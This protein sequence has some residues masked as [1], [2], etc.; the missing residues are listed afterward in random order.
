MARPH[1][2][3]LAGFAATATAFGPGRIGFG[4]FLPR[5]REAFDLSEAQAGFMTSLGFAAFLA[6]LPLAALIVR[7]AGP[8]TP[9]LLGALSALTGFVLVA[10]ASSQVF[11]AA[12]V[13]FAG[14]SAG[15]CWTPF[16]TAA[17]HD[18]S[19]TKRAAA[20]S[21]VSTGATLGVALAAGSFLIAVLAGLSWRAPWAV[22]AVMALFALALSGQWAPT[23]PRRA[24]APGP[25]LSASAFLRPR[26]I[27]LYTAALGFGLA[28]GA[29]L[30][31][32][33]VQVVSAGGLAGL[34]DPAASAAIFLIYGVCGLIGLASGAIEARIGL[35]AF[36][37]IIFLAFAA[38]LALIALF[39]ASWIG[40]GASAGLQGAAVMTVNAVLSFWSLRLFP[41]AGSSGFTAAL[42]AAAL[43]SMIGPAAA[44]AAVEQV[45]A[46]AALAACAAAP[47]LCAIAFALSGRAGPD[48]FSAAEPR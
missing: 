39:P 47:L 22:F 2:L 24:A 38:S 34:P 20:L 48:R 43:G 37:T 10:T 36:N 40:V 42:A 15:L 26:L 18:L 5:L 21:A 16:N 12:G 29:Y 31:Y 27:P 13:A 1:S 11:L 8:R 46:R 44:G 32:A 14:A 28:N 23:R 19:P 6:A 41:Q 33:G 30:A 9:V 7:R 25:G 35:A 45:G 17:E 4:L 3:A